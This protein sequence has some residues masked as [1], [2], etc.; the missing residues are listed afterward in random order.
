MNEFVTYS[1]EAFAL[2]VL[3]NNAEKWLQGARYPD[4]KKHELPKAIYT[5]SGESGNK[6]SMHGQKRYV[7]YV[8]S[9]FKDVWQ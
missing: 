6:W 4:L 2:I 3:E 5:E 7:D 1:D 8:L 9:A